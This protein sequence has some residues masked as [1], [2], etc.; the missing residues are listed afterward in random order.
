[1]LIEE[2][3]RRPARYKRMRA[4]RKAE[5]IRAKLR[6]GSRQEKLLGRSALPEEIMPSKKNEIKE[7]SRAYYLVFI[8]AT[9]LLTIVAGWSIFWYFASR[10]TAAAVTNWMTHEAQLGRNWTCPGQKIGGYPFTVEVSCANLLFQGKILG[11]ILIG[12]VRG[13]HATSPLLRNDNLLARIDSPFA[14]KTSDGTIDMTI[15]WGE[16]YIELEG[17]PGAY[18]RVAF[19]GTQVKVQGKMGTMDPLEGGFDEFHSNLSL[20]PDRHDSSYDFMFSFNDG[21]IPALNSLLD[22]QLPIGVQFGGAISQAEIGQVKTLADFLEKWRSA[23]G[24]LD[25]ATARLTS[26]GVQFEAKGGLDLD[27]QHRVKGKLDA[28][29][30]GF[31]KAF[32]QLNIDPGLVTA[33]QVLSGLLGK[34]SDVSGRLNLPVTF[35][36][37][38]LSI[39]PV[40]TSIQIPPLY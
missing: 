2:L 13:F 31:G 36:N 38:F 40:R 29:F 1:M 37:G 6:Q 26:G 22:T 15:Q 35:S 3:L 17:P 10:Q 34:G 12:T 39:G 11:K 24:H 25:I 8:P 28:G 30:A 32:R 4:T 7:H 33:G 20:A 21:S 23:N 14:A 19:A 16:L 18:E 9:M 5:L 27:D